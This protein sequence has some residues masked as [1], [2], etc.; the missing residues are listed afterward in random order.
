MTAPAEYERDA[1]LAA[2]RTELAWSRSVLALFACGAA[3]AKGL[4]KVTGREGRPGIGVAVL[5]L[6]AVVWLAGL[7]LERRR[8]RIGRTGPRPVA[9]SRELAPLAAGTVLV[10]VA[11]LVIE[12]FF[13]A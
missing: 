5:A 12:L 7:P 11:M 2:E 6:G 4:P 1:G 10:G 9:G 13:P 3:V 8:A